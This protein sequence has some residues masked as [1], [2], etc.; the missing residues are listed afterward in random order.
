MKRCLWLVEC[1]CACA[2]IAAAQFTRM[3]YEGYNALTGNFNGK[4]HIG[5]ALPN[6][7]LSGPGPYPVFI[8]IGGTFEQYD[9][10]MAA[11]LIGLMNLRGFVGASLE[12]DNNEVIQTCVQYL[13]R[14]QGMFDATRA[15]S[16]MGKLCSLS[17]AS[18]NPADGGGIV[19]MGASQGGFMGV[20]AKNYDA[21]V[22]AVYALSIGDS[23][24]S[25]PDYFPFVDK[26]NTAIPGDR[27]TVIDGISDQVFQPVQPQLQN[28]T[29]FTCPDGTYQCW[30]PDGSGA[31]WYIVQNWQVADGVAD[32]CY[33]IDDPKGNCIGLGDP[34]WLPPGAENWSLDP[35]LAWLASFGTQRVFSKDGY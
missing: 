26:Q 25:P 28:I 34:T 10:P 15:T 20:L 11:T 13:P 35:N 29:G 3:T 27:L 12:Y 33:F 14:A 9:D 23:T 18:C 24:P 8:W 22:Q 32:H 17:A 31:G 30:S 4:E 5:Y 19:V 7:N 1:L 21:R 2:A 16:A 6:P